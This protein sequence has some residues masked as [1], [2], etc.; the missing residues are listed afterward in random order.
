M[1]RLRKGNERGSANLGWL[2]SKHTFS[3]ADYDDPD[4]MGF[5]NLR[6]I[7]EDRVQPGQGFGSHGHRDMEIISYIIDGTLEHKDSMGNGSI[8]RRG[9]VQRMTAGSGV[10][11]SEFNPSPDTTVHFLQI[12][13][14]PQT[15]DL[16]PGY[17]QKAIMEEEKS[18]QL[19]LIISRDG[20]DDSLTIHQDVDLYA[21]LLTADCML[22]HP[23][24]NG[25]KGW[26]QVVLGDADVNEMHLVAGD[27]LALQ[28]CDQVRV[29]ALSD[30]ELL[31]FDMG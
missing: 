7:N 20:R 28:D 22:S 19:R 29:R 26:L 1:L 4:H 10:Q 16:A 12:W 24:G 13:I 3:F 23:F 14:L 17:E 9:D 21:S 27:G 30:T 5:G 31:L 18:N 6:V 25:R 15:L 11:H 2:D 8:M